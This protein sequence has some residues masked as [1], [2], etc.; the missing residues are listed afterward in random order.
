MICHHDEDMI[1]ELAEEYMSTYSMARGFNGSPKST[2]E[3]I[4]SG[5][6]VTT[7]Q[8]EVTSPNATK[9][10]NSIEDTGLRSNSTGLI[11]LM[12]CNYLEVWDDYLLQ[13]NEIICVHDLDAQCLIA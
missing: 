10:C 7:I 4:G 1:N 11:L 9:S 2:N 8:N 12:S 3:I 13:C 5:S 6:K